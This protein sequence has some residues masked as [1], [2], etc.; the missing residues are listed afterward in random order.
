MAMSTQFAGSCY[1]SH[2]WKCKNLAL[3]LG[4]HN[5][6]AGHA[7][8][9]QRCRLCLP[10]ILPLHVHQPL[11]IQAPTRH[12]LSVSTSHIRKG[13]TMVGMKALPAF[14]SKQKAGATAQGTGDIGHG[15][16]DIARLARTEMTTNVATMNRPD[17]TAEMMVMTGETFLLPLSSS[18]KS[19]ARLP[20]YTYSSV[21]GKDSSPL[22]QRACKC[23]PADSA[24]SDK[25]PLYAPVHHP[26]RP[27]SAGRPAYWGVPG[28]MP[29]AEA[30]VYAQDEMGV[31]DSA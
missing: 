24:D 11:L 23:P 18:P 9:C 15:H 13:V 26:G 16:L 12:A 10:N 21:P 6:A 28:M 31:T 27:L 25:L 8:P 2:T 1:F 19:F 3:G 22:S 20:R 14:S 4:M 5:S 30:Q 17:T 29:S 7:A